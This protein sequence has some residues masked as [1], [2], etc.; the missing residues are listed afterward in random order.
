[1]SVLLYDPAEKKHVVLLQDGPWAGRRWNADLHVCDNP[2]CSCMHVDFRCVPADAAPTD[3]AATVTFVLDTAKRSIYRA[4]GRRRS[5]DSNKLAEAVVKELEETGWKYLYEFLLGVKQEQIE[6]CDP[7]R[8]DVD[9]PPEV[10]RGDVTVVGYSE[11]FPLSA[12]LSFSMGSDRWY[13][14]DDYC[15]NPDC[16]CRNVVLQFV[17]REHERGISGAKKKSPPAMYYNYR[18]RTFEQAQAPEAHQHSLQDL[19]S[20]LKDQR[21]GFDVEVKKRH[22]M[23]KALF[24]RALSKSDTW[25]WRGQPA[26][27]SAPE[28]RPR[29]EYAGALQ[30]KTG[31]ND[32]CPCGSGKKYKKCCGR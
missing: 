30:P 25:A 18:D 7:R 24:K 27:A 13:A 4:A 8:L 14:V 29:T 32:P 31:R 23:L 6:K 2:C 21:P 10:L 19:L 22:K 17:T 12:A 1:M 9:F 3:Q 16:D 28:P 26:R 11:I 20:G 15:V 5:E